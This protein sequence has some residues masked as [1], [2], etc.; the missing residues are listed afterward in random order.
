MIICGITEKGDP[1]FDDSW[2]EWANKGNPTILVTKQFPSIHKRFGE[3][4]VHKKIITHV[5]ATGYGGTVFEPGIP[6]FTEVIEE[7]K[8]CTQ[9]E[10]DRIV[11][12][13]DPIIP[14]EPFLSQSFKCL[15]AA[16]AVGGIKRVRTS[17]MDY[18]RHVRERCGKISFTLQSDLDKAYYG[19]M[20]YQSWMSENSQIH[21]GYSER[22]NILSKV[23]GICKEAGVNLQI[24]GE[25]G[26]V[27]SGCVSQTDYELLNLNDD[28]SLAY[29]LGNRIGCNCLCTKKELL[30]KNLVANECP[31]KCVY[32]YWLDK[33]NKE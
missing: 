1:A 23:N 28:L 20:G 14:A 13:L 32:C 16:L 11:F 24:C 4:L 33:E 12:R 29:P 10:K 19:D 15:E 18:Y 2:L 8:T 7:L 27:C 17:I 26:F 30:K 21:L 6:K 22:Y 5:V 3:A 31:G 25:P 9:E